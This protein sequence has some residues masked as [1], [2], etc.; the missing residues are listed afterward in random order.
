M[1][2]FCE[3]LLKDNGFMC[4]LCALTCTFDPSRHTGQSLSE[5]MRVVEG[6]DAAANQFTA[7]GIDPGDTFE[8][9]L[10][11]AGDRDWIAVTLE[12]G[13]SYGI[14][15]DAYYSGGGGLRDSYLRIYDANGSFLNSND[16]GGPGLDSALEFTATSSGTYF[17]SV[18][19]YRDAYSGSYTLAVDENTTT[20]VS[21]TK[22]D[23]T[24]DE[25]ADYLTDG[26]WRE[27]G[28]LGRSFDTRYDNQITVNIT[29]LADAGQ[30][31]ARWAFDAWEMVADIVFVEVNSGTADISFSDDQGDNGSDIAVNYS[32]VY[33]T[34]ITSSQVQISAGW[35]DTYG[36]SVDS[37]SF[38]TYVHEIG[39]ALGLGHQGNYNGN[40]TYEDDAV[41]ANDSW[42]NS[43]MSYFSQSENTTT[44]A[45]EAAITSAMMAD[46]IAIQNL[47]GAAGQNSATAGDTRWGQDSDLDTYLG[48]LMRMPP[49]EA[50]SFTIYDATGTD[51]IDLSDAYNHNR[52]DLNDASF[53]DIG[54]LIGNIGIARGTMIENAVLGFGNDTVTGNELANDIEGAGGNDRM[55]GGAG[56]DRLLGQAGNDTLYGGEGADWLYGGDGRDVFFGGDQNDRLFGGRHNDRLRGGNGND[57]LNGG[58]GKDQLFGHN[59]NDNLSGGNQRDTLSG[60][61]GADRLDG[62]NG[63]DRLLGG[64][65]NDRLSGQNQ[66]DTLRG[67]SGNDTLMGGNGR[68]KLLGDRGHDTL[69][70]NAGRDTLVGGTGND[71]LDGGVSGDR[72]D[73]QRGND[74]L[75]GG[76]GDD[77]LT[78]GTGA[79]VFVFDSTRTTGTDQITDF[80]RG[81]D[82]ISIEGLTYDALHFTTRQNALDI[83]WDTGSV[84]VADVT[85][86]STD[87]FIFT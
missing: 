21:P 3:N 80:A 54:G 12:A 36:T 78:G 19:S 77:L 24:L 22:V 60:G 59:G 57:S 37:Y 14:A 41:F 9:T 6:S 74:T 39:H 10:S 71:R 50:I 83:V 4:D 2:V 29:E 48:D 42:Q 13:T 66:N 17:V 30:Q 45:S 20:P 28:R 32:S 8:G 16:D 27:T 7:Y 33:G 56:N 51:T 75:I 55:D 43:I 61:N 1:N 11:S 70:G 49:D 87:D 76:A 15:I 52:L 85:H 68:D 40:G 72:L 65:H 79:D 34:R 67:G 31:L 63:H 35:L 69:Q 47:Y 84:L 18:G 5:A 82:L 58:S 25:L 44:T 53:S 73:G 81:Q 38:Q 64:R 26:Y 86:L 23:A 62:G 46:I